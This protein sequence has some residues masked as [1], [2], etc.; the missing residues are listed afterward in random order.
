MTID[1]KPLI[2]KAE[3]FGLDT[4]PLRDLQAA[5]NSK[6]IDV[7]TYTHLLTTLKLELEKPRPKGSEPLPIK[8]LLNQLKARVDAEPKTIHAP[9]VDLHAIKDI[10]HT[11]VSDVVTQK[12]GTDPA[13]LQILSAMMQEIKDLKASTAIVPNPPPSMNNS[14]SSDLGMPAVFI[15]PL[16]DDSDSNLKPSVNIPTIKSGNMKDKLDR[17]RKL[18]GE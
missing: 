10:I 16:E 12:A 17:L 14:V 5:I 11:T 18:R 15:N 1:L 3:S 9:E 4:Q 13:V 8:L 2:T 6:A 7:N